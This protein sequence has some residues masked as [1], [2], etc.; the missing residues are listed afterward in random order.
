MIP[1][2]YQALFSLK[3]I[4]KETKNKMS[5]AAVVIDTFRA[6]KYFFLF[7]YLHVQNALSEGI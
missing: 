3:K 4:Q 1:M 2:K 6:K 5:S 7:I